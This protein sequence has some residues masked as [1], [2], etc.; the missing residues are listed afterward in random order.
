MG[1]VKPVIYNGKVV[2]NLGDAYLV[3]K[4]DRDGKNSYDTYW[5]T[6]NLS[7]PYELV[8]M[9]IVYTDTMGS[10][11]RPIISSADI[12]GYISDSSS[13]TRIRTSYNGISG[14]GAHTIDEIHTNTGFGGIYKMPNS[15]TCIVPYVKGVTN[16][17][18]DERYLVTV[19]DS[20]LI[21]A[22]TQNTSSNL[23]VKC[24]YKR[25][26]TNSIN[27]IDATV[28]A[29]VT[30]YS[31]YDKDPMVRYIIKLTDAYRLLQDDWML[32]SGFSGFTTNSNLV[33]FNEDFVILK[34]EILGFHEDT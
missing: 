16:P 11:I 20:K 12:V 27:T 3:R 6:N 8:P 23:A 21:L 25:I 30:H 10:M 2:S 5:T 19:V 26:S 13:A 17:L 15:H 24:T 28:D 4:Q 33:R 14:S 32:V 29:T 7:F 18:R 31:T 1:G 9:I 34:L 22:P